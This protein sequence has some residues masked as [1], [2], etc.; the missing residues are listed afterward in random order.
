MCKDRYLVILTEIY[1]GIM[2]SQDLRN[3]LCN[4]EEYN[5]VPERLPLPRTCRGCLGPVC[6]VL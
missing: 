3:F 1:D 6:G 2:C 5:G 4:T